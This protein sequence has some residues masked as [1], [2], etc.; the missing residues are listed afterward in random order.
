MARRIAGVQDRG[1]LKTWHDCYKCW[2]MFHNGTHCRHLPPPQPHNGC[3]PDI[4]DYVQ[5]SNYAA[6]LAWWLAFFPPEQ[7][8]ILTSAELRDPAQQ[9]QARASPLPPCIP[10]LRC[11]MRGPPPPL[12]QHA[13]GRVPVWRGG[14]AGRRGC[15][16]SACMQA[17]N[18]ILDH[19]NLPN[20]RRFTRDWLDGISVR[21]FAG[22]YEEED[23][24]RGI[25]EAVATLRERFRKPAE[26]LVHLINRFWPHMNF[27]G[28]PDEV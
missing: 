15:E 28:L 25:P 10:R 9:I 18:R 17:L 2:E 12:A 26:D 11:A 1:G 13:C 24:A 8:L 21:E 6:Q 7:I 19:A 14:Y 27:T 23:T 20:A 22:K 5:V 4:L 16:C 3:H